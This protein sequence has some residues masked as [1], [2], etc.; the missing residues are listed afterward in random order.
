MANQYAELFQPV[1]IGK[2]EIKNRISMPPMGNGFAGNFATGVP[3]D[4]HLHYFEARAKG[5]FG[6]IFTD[7]ATVDRETGLRAPNLMCID[8]DNAIP[9]FK[10]LSDVVHKHGTKIAVQIVHP[11]RCVSPDF[12]GGK[13]PL[14]PSPIP[15]PT[16]N[17]MPREITIAEIQYLVEKF[18]QAAR[19]VKEAGFDAVMIH[20][21][22]GY[23]ISQFMSTYANKRTDEYGGGFEGFLRFPL[24][25]VKRTRE[26]VGPDFPIVF[27]ISGDEIVA[28]GRRVPESVEMMKRLVAAGVDA[29]DV[30]VACGEAIHYNIASANLPMGFNA[31]ASY[32][33]KMALKNTPVL[34]VGRINEPEIA[35]DIIRSGKADIVQI[36]RQ[37]LADPEWP[38]KVREGRKEDIVRCLSCNE[39]CID[40]LIWQRPQITCIQNLR[41]GRE[42]RYLQP[43]A[44]KSKKVL[45]AGGGPGGMEAARTAALR[46]H[47]V[48]LYEKE[49]ELGGQIKLAATPPSK[50]IYIELLKSRVKALKELNVD[51]HTGEALTIQIIKA[52]K[53][54]VLIIATGSEPIMLK[55]PGIENANVMS[56]REALVSEVKGNNILVLGG[57]L[58]GCETA[59]YLSEK[60]K[61]ITIIEM[62]DRVAGDIGP[63]AAHF[64]MKRLTDKKVKILPGTTVK[65]CGGKGITIESG[66]KQQN[67]GTFDT[68]VLAVGAKAVN[69][70]EIEARQ[71]VAE[72][73][74]I[75]DASKPGKI[76][77]AVEAAVELAFKL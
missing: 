14:A 1:K 56:A 35:V 75:G 24:E 18:A 64:L 30:S 54:D 12:I 16:E 29:A 22:H 46:G 48:T 13:T 36:G 74:S 28:S 45:V 57:G 26:V 68:V 63:A 47:K 60:G 32:Q 50:E 38:N 6:L 33:F 41:V 58:V 67:L 42:E 19:R 71:M 39:A 4:T 49:K 8:N 70:F 76:L 59:D 73:H 43:K 55:I 9:G 10:K 65:S 21:G 69:D 61:K 23:L 51:I 53:P 66:G 2:L 31:D 7:M 44:L 3:S 34:V 25:I 11:G 52:I 20:G 77:E 17:H 37:S 27:R 5:G 72:V 15:D 62:L 40:S